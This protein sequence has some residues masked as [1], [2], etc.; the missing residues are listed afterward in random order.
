MHSLENLIAY[1][2]ACKQDDLYREIIRRILS[3]IHK[4]EDAS[5]YDF[6]EMCFVSTTTISRLSR[7][8]GYK[9]FIDFKMEL[10]NSVKNYNVLNRYVPL[11]EVSR[12]GGEQKAY[13]ELMQKQLQDFINNIDYSEIDNLVEIIHSF[14]KI[15]FYTYGISFAEHHFQEDL[16][17]A[18]H[19]CS[20]F[21]IPVDQLQDVETLD[22]NSLVIA[23][24]PVVQESAVI[25]K[26]LKSV[27][28][29]K[30]K[31]FMLTDSRYSHYL[32]YADY[33]FCFDGF[34]S[35]IDDYRFSM[36]LNLLSIAYRNKYLI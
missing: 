33:S 26:V 28:E 14:K 20:L 10:S 17:M 25:N 31:I 22:E 8:L 7:K 6:A 13:L 36:H 23:S 3:N 4:I 19:D 18:G 21:S 11:N 29:K 5:I 2:N 15:S 1:Y 34:M 35:I 27:K 16:I 12:Y 30:S 32:K 9:S 24:L